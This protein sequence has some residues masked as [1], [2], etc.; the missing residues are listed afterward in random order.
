MSL[1]WFPFYVGDWLKDTQDLTATERGYYISLLVAC[2]SMGHIPKD[3]D[4]LCR[5]CCEYAPSNAQIVRR[6]ADRYFKPNGEHLTHKRVD[7]ELSKAKARTEKAL[8]AAQKRWADA[9]SNAS[10]NAPSNAPAMLTTTTVQST[11]T[12]RA[13]ARGDQSPTYDEVMTRAEMRAI[14][15]TV[16]ESW[17]LKVE[18]NGWV[19]NSGNPITNWEASLRLFAKNWRERDAKDASAKGKGRSGASLAYEAKAKI[20]AIER[21]GQKQR[22]SKA[23]RLAWK[24]D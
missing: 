14:P 9:P 13:R 10:G 1:H 3:L 22:N 18:A 15:Q 17:W 11:P 19:D 6:V 4:A 12:V 21:T 7:K 5:I 2:Y 20:E 16:A 8:R 24:G 23:R